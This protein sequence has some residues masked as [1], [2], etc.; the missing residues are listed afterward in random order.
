MLIVGLGGRSFPGVF[1][2]SGGLEERKCTLPRTMHVGREFFSLSTISISLFL[3]TYFLV[4][5]LRFLVIV[6]VTLLF[7]HLEQVTPARVPL[8]FC[9]TS[10]PGSCRHLDV[11]NAPTTLDLLL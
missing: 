3:A 11:S 5:G 2:F 9:P 8:S 7:T 4:T 6:S 1:C 10:G